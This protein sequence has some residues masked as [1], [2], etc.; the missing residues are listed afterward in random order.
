VR[1]TLLALGRVGLGRVNLVRAGL[2]G[3]LTVFDPKTQKFTQ[4]KFVQ[5]LFRE[6]HDD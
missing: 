3:P 5:G 6:L 1:F 4:I 2:G